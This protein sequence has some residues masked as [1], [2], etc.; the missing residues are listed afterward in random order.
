[1]AEQTQTVTGGCLCGAIRY[2]TNGVPERSGYC[3]CRSCR[4]H[5]GAPVTAFV[6]FKPDQ[7]QWLSGCRKR[8]E[9]SPGVFRS[10][11]PDCGTSLTWEGHHSESDW[12]EFHISTLDNP[13]EFPPENHSHFAERISW[14]HLTGE[15]SLDQSEID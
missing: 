9:S 5:T 13:A 7:V 10:F 8:Y 12:I 4:H 11:C 6:D 3:P 14:L 2:V 1:M 15:P